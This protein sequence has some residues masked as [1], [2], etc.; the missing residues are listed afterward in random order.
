MKNRTNFTP[1]SEAK[2]NQESTQSVHEFFNNIVESARKHPDLYSPA[3]QAPF[4][5]LRTDMIRDIPDNISALGIYA[6]FNWV[7]ETKDNFLNDLWNSVTW[8]AHRGAKVNLVVDLLDPLAHKQRMLRAAAVKTL[9]GIAYPEDMLQTEKYFF[10]ADLH[11]QTVGKRQF[12]HAYETAVDQQHATN[13]KVLEWL[14]AGADRGVA[15]AVQY[16]SKDFAPMLHIAIENPYGRFEKVAQGVYAPFISTEDYSGT[17]SSNGRAAMEVELSR[18]HP[19][20]PP[21]EASERAS[22]IGNPDAIRDAKAFITPLVYE[23]FNPEWSF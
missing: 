7:D 21:I 4:G 20:Y 23:G 2:K 9:G 17:M 16:H 18:I 11:F 3:I 5:V 10:S 13:A 22:L 1:T 19:L 12:K 6:K 15:V 8:F 14:D